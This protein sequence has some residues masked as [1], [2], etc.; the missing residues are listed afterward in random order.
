[1]RNAY[2]PTT[3]IDGGIHK[4]S[5]SKRPGIAMLASAAFI[6]I[7]IATLASGA[8]LEGAGVLL[9]AAGCSCIGLDPMKRQ[10]R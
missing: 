8:V 3:E 9:V 2:E 7:G 10:R 6:L 1:M 5:P 4:E